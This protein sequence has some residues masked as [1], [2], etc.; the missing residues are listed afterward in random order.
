[1]IDPANL[2][3][4]KSWPPRLLIMM[5]ITAGA[6]LLTTIWVIASDQ[7]ESIDRRSPGKDFV[8]HVWGRS[9][10]GLRDMAVRFH[11]DRVGFASRFRRRPSDQ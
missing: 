7:W 5:S 6:L 1:M 2:P 11:L 3:E 8:M 4:K 10:Q 9:G